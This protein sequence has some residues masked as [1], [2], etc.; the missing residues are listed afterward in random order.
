MGKPLETKVMLNDAKM[1]PAKIVDGRTYVQ[2]REI[3]DML[4]L[5][6]VYNDD[7]KKN[8]IVRGRMIKRPR[9]LYIAFWPFFNIIMG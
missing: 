9:Q 2:V 1:I 5:K 4:N 7:S 8:K 6:L 3:A